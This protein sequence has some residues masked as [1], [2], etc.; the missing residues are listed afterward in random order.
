[1]AT[2]LMLGMCFCSVI[3]ASTVGRAQ[4]AHRSTI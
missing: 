4:P 1:L 2:S 3:D